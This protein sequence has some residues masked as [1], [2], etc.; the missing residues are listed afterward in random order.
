[1]TRKKGGLRFCVWGKRFLLVFVVL[2]MVV[3]PC[4]LVS[5]VLPQKYMQMYA[6]NNIL[7][8]DPCEDK[9]KACVP[10]TGDQITWIGDSYSVGAAPIIESKLSGISFGGSINDA[11]STIQ[12]SKFVES[13]LASNP[14]GIQ[15]LQKIKD[16]GNLKPYLVFALGA[17]GGID[18]EQIRRVVDIAGE[19]TQIVFANLYM[20]ISDSSVQNY[21]KTSNIALDNAKNQ[22][23]NVSVADWA[24]VAKDD[25]YSSDPSDTHP[26]GGY[27]E[28]VDTIIE[29]MPQNCADGDALLPGANV[30]EKIWNWLVNYFNDQNLSNVDISALV[31][32]IMGN[33]YTESGLNPLMSSSGYYGLYM[34]Y[35]AYG[36]NNYVSKVNAKLGG[37]Y[38]KFYG[39]WSDENKVDSDLKNAGLDDD[40]IDAAIDIN[41]Q[42]M[43][44]GS[45]WSEFMTGVKGW[46]VA[47]TARG[48]ADLFLAVMERAT[49]G[50][51]A[52]EDAGV[53]NHYNGSY[54]GATARRDKADY[55]YNKYADASSVNPRVTLTTDA[56]RAKSKGENKNYAGETVW[57]EEQMALVEKYESV[58]KSASQQYDVPWQAIATMHRL[59]TGLSLTNPSNGQ[60]LYQLYSYTGGGSN[61]NAFPAGE[62]DMTEFQRQTNIAAEQMKK[63][64]EKS[65]YQADS[66]NG[67]KFLLF[68]YNGRASQ[69]IQKALVMGFSQEEADVGEGSPYVMNRYDARRD[70]N[71]SQMD[72][73]WP[74]RFVADGVY[75]ENSKMSDFGGFV[76]Y[77]A[78]GGGS[79]DDDNICGGPT[80]NGDIAEYVLKYAWPE[81]HP[82]VFLDVMPDYKEAYLRRKSEG[83]YVGSLATYA[84]CG[85]FVTTLLQ[86]SGFD[87]NY[88]DGGN[89]YFQERY[90]INSP[91]WELVNPSYSTPISDESKLSPGDVAF[92]NCGS[93]PLNCSHTYVYV[94][95]IAGF[96][97]HIASA[98][99]DE[100]TPMAGTE[101]IVGYGVNWYHKVR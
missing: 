73:N 53:R 8:Y 78:L 99:W 83:K 96:S 18:A 62:V 64:I 63:L 36:G 24:A 100:R 41:L 57:S 44:G 46:G 95:E 65:G 30:A 94:G 11:N 31:S 10:P 85:G 16:A 59:E 32:G 3:L 76:L 22:Y 12:G 38:F 35:G 6:Q 19:D 14:G 26:F 71:S 69:Y 49:P 48:Y 66:D 92:S 21:I 39:W 70:P 98:S 75:D 17:N 13:S 33:F 15:I 42:T 47:N 68:S 86:E 50:D 45:Y 43:T 61:S 55:F 2:V 25:Y 97:S 72:S 7:Y 60:G 77:E 34:L 54:Q 88:G 84:D 40:Q 4:N 5:A 20:P 1:M 29:A 89:T 79:G 51:S 81:Y 87:P 23:N 28:W 74:G 101:S 93:T 9:E 58:Y 91:D 90:V 52:I 67:I 56:D 80:T 82:A 37:N 27:D